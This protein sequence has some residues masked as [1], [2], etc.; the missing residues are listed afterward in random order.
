MA[1]SEH[2]MVAAVV[3]TPVE[4][5]KNPPPLASS[6]SIPSSGTDSSSS[7]SSCVVVVSLKRLVTLNVGPVMPGMH[8]AILVCSTRE[9]YSSSTVTPL[10]LVSPDPRPCPASSLSRMLYLSAAPISLLL[11]TDRHV[12]MPRSTDPYGR[13][14]GVTVWTCLGLEHSGSTLTHEGRNCQAHG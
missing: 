3:P 10:L 4:L 6:L 12:P 14:R 13:D 11:S 2:N 8:Y 7:S 1:P 5:E 9:L